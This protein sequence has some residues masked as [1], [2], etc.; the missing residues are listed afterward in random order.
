MLR[1]ELLRWVNN[2]CS[3]SL[4]AKIWGVTYTHPSRNFVLKLWSRWQVII[5]HGVYISLGFILEEFLLGYY[6]DWNIIKSSLCYYY[7]SNKGKTYLILGKI[8]DFTNQVLYD[9]HY[10]SNLMI[11]FPL[12]IIY[13]KSQIL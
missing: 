6:F 4:K 7:V 13:Y 8:H 9:I 3:N 12:T 2:Q 10:S 5:M 1:I 11:K